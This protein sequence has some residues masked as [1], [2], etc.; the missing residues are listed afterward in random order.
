LVGIGVYQF[1]D[2]LMGWNLL[3]YIKYSIFYPWCGPGLPEC[4]PTGKIKSLLYKNFKTLILSV[5]NVYNIQKLFCMNNLIMDTYDINDP[6][7]NNG[8]ISD[9]MNINDLDRLARQ[10][11]DN[12]K[13]KSN[14]VLNQYRKN[15]ENLHN[16]ITTFN[17]I[18]KS[19]IDPGT[20]TSILP[21]G[22][23]GGFYSAQGNYSEYKPNNMTGTLIKDICTDPN[24]YQDNCRNDKGKKLYIE[25]DSDP[26]LD[27]PSANNDSDSS[28]S[29]LTWDT[30]K[31]DKQIKTISK[32]NDKK[33]SK[34]HKCMDFDLDSV[35]SLESLDSGESLLRHI[36][37][38]QVCKIKVMDLIRKHKIDSAKKLKCYKKKSK[39][40]E[41]SI[42]GLHPG[43][44]DPGSCVQGP[45]A[46]G[47]LVTGPRASGTLDPGS[48]TPGSRDP[49]SAPGSPV[50][51]PDTSSAS[52]GL[53]GFHAP[54]LKEIVTVCLI[55]FLVIVLLDLVMRK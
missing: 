11:N 18:Q 15:A 50:T 38:C 54:E 2:L 39:Y 14:G 42:N 44:R 4:Q 30:K 9:N 35:D 33:R 52:R 45:G 43:S 22:S 29:S 12:K 21:L 34:R 51:E 37:F 5:R 31:I 41:R 6:Y 13:A 46:S 16:G 47:T 53:L 32:F 10:V 36:R 8:M 20:S 26:L 3:Q 19:Q 48:G 7:M 27:T 25:N 1:I 24:N 49:G 23:N 55:G 28:F 40:L 17:K